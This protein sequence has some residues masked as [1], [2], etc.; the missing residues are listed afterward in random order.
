[1]Y[2]LCVGAIDNYLSPIEMASQG[3]D[4]S[5]CLT[6]D[7]L[8]AAVSERLSAL[9]AQHARQRQVLAFLRL[10]REEKRA[11]EAA[12][13]A[14]LEGVAEEQVQDKPKPDAS[15]TGSNGSLE[16]VLARAR[17]MRQV[18]Q[19][20]QHQASSSSSAQDSKKDSKTKSKS[21]LLS[22]KLNAALD[23]AKAQP[24]KGE[25]HEP[26]QDRF[27]KTNSP[28]P[29]AP[30]SPE[31]NKTSPVADL[32]AQLAILT[33]P[34]ISALAL[35]SGGGEDG[36]PHRGAAL[37]MSRELWAAQSG[38]LTRLR[39]V[40]S[41]PPSICFSLVE[42]ER[43]LAAGARPATTAAAQAQRP[44]TAPKSEPPHANLQPMLQQLQQQFDK[45][46]K[47]RLERQGPAQ[48][49]VQDRVEL[50]RMWYRLQKC[51]QVYSHL[52]GSP[53]AL[54]APA[55]ATSTATAAAAGAE[56]ERVAGLL[57]EL[58]APLPLLAP[59]PAPSK[60][61]TL[62]S[63]EWKA[64]ARRCVDDFHSAL[65]SRVEF[66]AETAVGKVF[67][68]SVL[69]GLRACVEAPEDAERWKDALRAYRGAHCLLLRQAQSATSCLFITKV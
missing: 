39:G 55:P 16:D 23:L 37:T 1:M 65:Q 24:K 21:L 9:E 3:L 64:Q 5:V 28:L 48:L 63:P 52:R 20:Q 31:R 17:V 60:L 45:V 32:Q 12:A 13:D 30:Q 61:Q 43:L 7:S 41:F 67:L 19:Q 66:T 14:K 29:L 42:E 4:L 68:K 51:L 49:G 6:L 33:N 38:L 58:I 27:A 47:S 11:K 22:G 44:N 34:A 62:A 40:P 2:H 15:V 35:A 26:P 56:E 8:E 69:R 10:C 25:T 46:W 59:T 53:S 50:L 54:A 36:A 18:K 57:S